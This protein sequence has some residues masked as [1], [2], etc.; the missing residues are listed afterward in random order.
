MQELMTP[1]VWLIGAIA[2]AVF[3]GIACTVMD[4]AEISTLVPVLIA[5]ILWFLTVPLILGSFA[6]A[7]ACHGAWRVMRR[8]ERKADR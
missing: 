7:A 2:T 8:L 1:E 5:S 6:A 4:S 3:F